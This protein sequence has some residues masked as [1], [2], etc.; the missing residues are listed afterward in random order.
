MHIY[1]KA[2]LTNIV[3]PEASNVPFSIDKN[4]VEAFYALWEL[5]KNLK[6]SRTNP[7]ILLYFS[8]VYNIDISTVLR[9]TSN[10]T[11]VEELMHYGLNI[12]IY[13][14]QQLK[15]KVMLLVLIFM[16]KCLPISIISADY[17]MM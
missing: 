6:F 11:L 16:T 8:L 13:I 5:V 3:L 9:N 10:P 12:N 1:P 17:L 15:E 7:H 4:Q 2:S 14:N